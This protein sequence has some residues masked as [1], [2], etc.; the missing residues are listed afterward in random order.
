[1]WRKYNVVDLL[2]FMSYCD[3]HSTPGVCQKVIPEK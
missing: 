3:H 1:L 2:T